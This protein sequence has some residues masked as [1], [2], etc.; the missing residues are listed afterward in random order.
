MTSSSWNCAQ[1]VV[2]SINEVAC[3]RPR[4]DTGGRAADHVA[5][6]PWRPISILELPKKLAGW[7]F[8]QNPEEP[9]IVLANKT[10]P[11]GIGADNMSCANWEKMAGL[12]GANRS[13]STAASCKGEAAMS[14][15]AAAA[16]TPPPPSL[17]ARN[18][19]LITLKMPAAD[20]AAWTAL[21]PPAPGPPHCPGS[22]CNFNASAAWPVRRGSFVNNASTLRR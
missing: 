15:A 14:G 16:A 11:A 10:L 7:C 8:V 18:V 2:V 6:G 19:A 21:N 12:R 20:I 13:C 3:Y 1:L 4:E 22:R 5:G 9:V 17:C